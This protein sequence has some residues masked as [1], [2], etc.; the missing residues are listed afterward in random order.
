MTRQQAI[1]KLQLSLKDFTRLCILK[2]VYPREPLH[3][4]KA[5]KGGTQSHIFYHVRDVNFLAHEPL[6]NKFREYKIFLRKLTKAKAK[7]DELKQ[8]SLIDQKPVFRLDTVLRERCAPAWRANSRPAQVP[9]LPAGA[10]R[11]RRRA[12]H[13]LRLLRAHPLEGRPPQGD[14]QLPPPHR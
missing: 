14:R 7:K 2:G 6:I 3:V 8:Q 11:P 10:A 5:N 1:R 9:D 4:K 13:V 12:L